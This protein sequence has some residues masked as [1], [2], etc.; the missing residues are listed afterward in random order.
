MFSALRAAQAESKAQSEGEG[1]A[2]PVATVEK[3]TLL[4]VP[5]G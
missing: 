2:P 1:Y 3:V 5:A 4:G